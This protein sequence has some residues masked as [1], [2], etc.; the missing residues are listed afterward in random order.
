MCDML[1]LTLIKSVL[2]SCAMLT[3]YTLM[4]IWLIPNYN[5]NAYVV[6]LS[7]FKLRLIHN[8]TTHSNIYNYTHTIHIL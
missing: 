2:N 4:S 5:V 8:L 7:D 1:L 6:S 3:S